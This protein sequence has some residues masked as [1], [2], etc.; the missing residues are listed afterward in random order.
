[1]RRLGLV[2]LAVVLLAMPVTAVAQEESPPSPPARD[3]AVI[4]RSDGEK[5][6]RIEVIAIDDPYLSIPSGYEASRGYG[7][8]MV[9]LKV[10][11]AELP[12]SVNPGQFSIV[13]SEG[14][15]AGQSTLYR[16]EL[17][18]GEAPDLNSNPIAG[19]H[20][21]TGA[22]FFQV[23]AT[24]AIATIEYANAGDQAVIVGDY[25]PG[26]VEPGSVVDITGNDGTPM[27]TIATGGRLDPVRDVDSSYSSPP[28]GF[29]FIGVWVTL[30]NAGDRTAIVDPNRF[31]AVDELGFV[32]VSISVSRYESGDA[33]PPA[34]TY[35]E[36]EPG[37]SV[38][39]LVFF[40]MIEPATISAIAYSPT[41][42]RVIRVAEVAAGKALPPLTN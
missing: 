16:S 39:G 13:D 24:A 10:T 2:L 19:G 25:R 28:R 34:L 32:S 40:S 8:V 37:D 41:W 29:R 23:Y 12:W 18:P 4:Y 21:V 33:Q 6:G 15:V 9:T 14:F 5:A 31:I 36:L 27:L 1:M 35:T 22:L 30:E 3:P 17:L 26:L 7:W 42:D 38:S 11:A 20:S